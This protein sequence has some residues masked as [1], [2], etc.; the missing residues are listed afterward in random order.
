MARGTARFIRRIDGWT[1]EDV[2]LYLVDPPI[3]YRRDDGP[4]AAHGETSKTSYMIVADWGGS[5]YP[6]VTCVFPAD[7]KGSVLAWRDLDESV[8]DEYAGVRR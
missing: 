4:G 8:L 2:S 3:T 5:S 7:S 6:E 1:T